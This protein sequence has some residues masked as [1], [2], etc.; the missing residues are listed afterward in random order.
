M[1]IRDS[2]N[3]VERYE[4]NGS[5]GFSITAT[6]N[7]EVLIS[8]PLLADSM[9]TRL[10]YFNGIDTSHFE[11]FSDETTVTGERIIIWRVKWS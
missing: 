8:D 11:K 2:G 5:L 6:R 3:G 1:C 7:G 4:L 10:F 9:F